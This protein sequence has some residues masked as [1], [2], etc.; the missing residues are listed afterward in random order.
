VKTI[1]FLK[2]W[3]VGDAGGEGIQHVAGNTE[4]LEDEIADRAIA[5]GAAVEVE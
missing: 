4:T 2:D 3:F 5:A 1:K